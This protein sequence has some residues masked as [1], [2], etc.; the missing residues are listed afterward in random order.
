MI[1]NNVKN[2]I[3]ENEIITKKI[4][5]KLIGADKGTITIEYT[6]P[7]ECK[8]TDCSLSFLASGDF[9][10]NGGKFV[11]D[12]VEYT[13]VEIGES[14][15]HVIINWYFINCNLTIPSTIK[16]IGDQAFYGNCSHWSFTN[17]EIINI[18]FE[19][20]VEYIGRC[21]FKHCSCEKSKIVLPNS[22]KYIGESAFFCT[23]SIKELDLTALDHVINIDANPFSK[24]GCLYNTNIKTIWVKDQT[25]KDKYYNDQYWSSASSKI[26]VKS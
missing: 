22:I 11:Y 20:G 3:N 26:K 23:R 9:N 4:D 17:K 14:A 15:F 13:I 5:A 7:S 6:T 24:Y 18:N 21:A 10:F 25:M 1:K 2:N 16:K 12:G 19:E 8:I